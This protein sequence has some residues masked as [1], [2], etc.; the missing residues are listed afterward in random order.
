MPNINREGLNSKPAFVFGKS[1]TRLYLNLNFPYYFT[2]ANSLKIHARSRWKTNATIEIP[3][4]SLWWKLNHTKVF[5]LYNDKPSNASAVIYF[6][7]ANS[8][9]FMSIYGCKRNRI[10]TITIILE[11]S[12]KDKNAR[13]RWVLTEIKISGGFHGKLLKLLQRLYWIYWK[14]ICVSWNWAFY[15]HEKCSSCL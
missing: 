3:L 1:W 5:F 7:R 10:W 15:K 12:R 8:L 11:R 9:K 6:T 13:D 4:I 2:C 14:T